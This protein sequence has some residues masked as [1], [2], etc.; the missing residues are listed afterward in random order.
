[1]NASTPTS[2]R[3]RDPD[4]LNAGAALQRAARKA[5]EVAL[6]MGTPCYV[7]L[8]GKIVNIGAAAKPKPRSDASSIDG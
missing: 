7:W 3:T 6:Q 2:T 4:L 5:L 8:D 1:M